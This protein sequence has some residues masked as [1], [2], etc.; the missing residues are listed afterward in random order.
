MRDVL[1]DIEIWRAHG[2]RVAL[3]TVI[4]MAGSAPRRP[5][6]KLA[7]SEKGEISGSVSGGCVEPAVIETA[8]Q[9]IKNGR[10]QLLEFG[11]TEEENIEQIGL[12]CGGTIQVF[13]ERLDW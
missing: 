4:S 9:V 3:A 12:A 8:M 7:V 1:P 13:V 2:E 6:A 5:G 10:P 11:I